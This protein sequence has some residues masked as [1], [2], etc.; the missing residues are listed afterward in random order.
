MKEELE[1]KAQTLLTGKTSPIA[2]SGKAIMCTVDGCL[3]KASVECEVI[4]TNTQLSPARETH[5]IALCETHSQAGDALR[6]DWRRAPDAKPGSQL[7][8]DALFA[9][10]TTED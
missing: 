5:R 2:A 7:K 3:H 4:V 9:L 8:L 1:V 6:W 10:D